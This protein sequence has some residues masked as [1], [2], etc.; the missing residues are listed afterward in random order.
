[1]DHILGPLLR[2]AAAEVGGPEALRRS[3]AAVLE[4]AARRAVA[5][6]VDVEI[7][8]EAGTMSVLE[9]RSVVEGNAEPDEIELAQAQAIDPDADVGDELGCA[10][11]L[12]ALVPHLRGA[13]VV[14]AE[15][16][17]AFDALLRDLFWDVEVVRMLPRRPSELD[18]AVERLVAALRESPF[19]AGLRP[20]CDAVEM[21]AHELMLGGSLPPALRR[22]LAGTAG[23]EGAEGE[24]RLSL[25]GV[26]YR[27]LSPLESQQ[28]HAAWTQRRE[29]APPRAERAGAAAPA[30]C[31]WN[32]D[33]MPIALG[34]RGGE[35]TDLLVVDSIGATADQ[36]GELLSVSFE[37]AGWWALGIDVSGLAH[38]WL[39]L[40]EHG[41]LRYLPPGVDAIATAKVEALVQHLL[42]R[43][44]WVDAG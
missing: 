29:E 21:Q 30:A 31:A 11:D 19:A 15:H 9:Y 4:R 38:V 25:G 28:E 5:G 43:R 7:D 39:V 16:Y 2:R 35:P 34:D 13:L 32:T 40:L 6:V 33:W 37:R 36:P 44:R 41:L 17:P 20:G 14:P 23:M 18:T 3:L 1:M 42:P 12:D 27:L 8:V 26:G 10:V 22:L 24:P